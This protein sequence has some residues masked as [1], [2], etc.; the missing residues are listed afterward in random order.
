M[1]PIEISI[2]EMRERA[3]RFVNEWK[4][5]TYERGESQSFW[6]DWFQVFGIPRRSVAKFEHYVERLS[7]GHGFIDLFWPGYLIVEQKSARKDLVGAEGQAFDYLFGLKHAEMP[8]IVISSDFERFIVRDLES[9]ATYAFALEEFPERVEMFAWIAGHERR[10]FEHEDEVNVKAA[11]LMGR[12]YDLLDDS[13]YGGHELRTLLVRLLFILFADDTGIWEHNLFADYLLNQTAEDGRDTG[14]H[15]GQ[16]FQVLNTPE[17]RRQT[18]LDASLALFPYINGDLFAEQISLPSFDSRMRTRLADACRFDWKAISPAV[19]GSMFQSVMNREERRNLGAHYTREQNILKL[20]GPLFLDELRVEF[21]EAS[22]VK[23]LEKLHERLAT[24][25][26]LDPACGCGNFLIVSY[27]EIRRLELD[28]MRRIRDLKGKHYQL[29]SDIDYVR[30]VKVSQFHGIE[31]E[32]F[33]ARIAET[34]MYLMDHLMNV[35]LER[36]FGIWTPEFPIEVSAHIEQGNA[37][38]LDWNLVL[39]A[40]ECSF[41]LG[42]PPFGGMAFMAEEQQED[43]ETAFGGINSKGLR[44]GRLDY[45]ACWYAAAMKYMAGTKIR[46]AF[47][48]T[49]SI[50][51]GEQAR[52]LGPLL[53]RNGFEID[54]AHRTFKWSSEAPGAAQVHVVIVGFSE[55]GQA[56][57]K[58]IFDVPKGN[59]DPTAV[60]VKAINSYLEGHAVTPSKRY[61]PWLS[62]LP[63]ASKG[64]QPTD[65]GYLIVEPEDYERVAGDS[66][67]RKYLRPF[68]QSTEMLYDKPRW[69]L[70]LADAQPSDIRESSVLR[71]RLA[72]VSAAR[73]K[74]KT[75]SVR[76]QAATPALFTQIRQPRCRYLA[77][78][79]V[80]TVN[81]DFIPGRY[82]DPDVIAGNKLILW[83]DAP[84]WLFG[85]LQSSAFMSW[86]TAFSGRMKSDFMIA[87]S[88]VYFTF[89]FIMPAGPQLQAVEQRA[90]A[91]LDTR[92]AHPGQTLADLYDR[93]AMPSDL[94]AAH[95]ELD[96]AIERLYGLKKP[97]P[98]ERLTRLLAEYQRLSAPLT[99]LPAHRRQTRARE[100]G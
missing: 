41:V 75:A 88:T 27:R 51:Q 83:P 52:T 97:T 50:T 81:R 56:K 10:C 69:C 2:N 34:A 24:M 23:A 61:E 66:I 94:R 37:I 48:S 11:E 59:T 28:I 5:E 62:G 58:L 35:E 42:N 74:S 84:L 46:A 16:L 17:D 19:F 25:S 89:P 32:E 77:L 30:K 57:A 100:A 76:E 68:R 1:T 18:S 92:D 91:V 82:Y 78:P 44:T 33:P 36:E 12:L 4:G 96:A 85:Y 3:A 9:G 15:L 87:P 53:E 26:L 40:R 39:P 7:G 14:M 72:L 86:V 47:V 67:A 45:V 55:G 71:S 65:G 60:A 21:A 63:R 31:L 22:S 80:S 93:L 90:Q 29:T 20:I 95:L 13:G 38:R 49:N 64:S 6:N 70:W 79:E 8:R 98:A 54:F 99:T 43:N 73:L